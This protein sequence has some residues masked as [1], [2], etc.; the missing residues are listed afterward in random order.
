MGLWEGYIGIYHQHSEA[1]REIPL[2]ERYNE[3][4]N[5][6]NAIITQRFRVSL[7]LF[8]FSW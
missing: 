8:T 4:L 3:Q 2:F 5:D 7:A 1:K 6:K